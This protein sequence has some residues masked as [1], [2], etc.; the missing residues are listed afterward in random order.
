MTIYLYKKTHNKTGLQYLGK[1]T[2]QDPH[3]YKG[4]GDHWIPHI[5]KH[6][7]DVTTEIL[8]ECESSEELSF[9]GRHYSELWNI[10]DSEEWAN[11]IPETGGGGGLSSEQAVAMNIKKVKAGTHSFLTRSDG[12]N[13]SKDN[14]LSGKH[15]FLGGDIQRAMNK[16]TLKAG[17]HPS[18]KQWKCEHCG[19]EGKGAS[20]YTKHHGAVCKSYPQTSS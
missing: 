4:S 14:V 2:Q 13:V 19:K 20:N 3:K 8:K 6:G 15:N 16:R 12:T 17:T 10:V 11:K 5:K 1:T 9:W 18:Q 7:Y